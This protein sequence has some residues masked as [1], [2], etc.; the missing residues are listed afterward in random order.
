MRCRNSAKNVV[1]LKTICCDSGLMSRHGEN[2]RADVAT[3]KWCR[4]IEM[5]FPLSDLYLFSA[6]LFIQA[7]SIR[8]IF[9]KSFIDISMKRRFLF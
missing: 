2:F 5:N 9:G 4:D 1:T 3:W 6:I 8:E 7:Y